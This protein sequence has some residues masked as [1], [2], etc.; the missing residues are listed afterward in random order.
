MKQVVNGET[1]YSVYGQSGA[2]LYRD[3][4]TTGETTDY[5]RMGGMTVARIKDDGVTET[6]SYLH[7][8]H[9]GS[10]VAATDT[11]GAVLWREDYTPFGEERQDPAANDNDE[12]FTGHIRDEATGLLY[13]QARYMD[14]ILGRFLSNDPVAFSSGAPQFF[15]RYSYAN[16]DPVNNFDP[17][18]K[19][20]AAAGGRLA[21]AGGFAIADGPFPFGDAIAVG[22]LIYTGAEL[23]LNSNVPQGPINPGATAGIP[24]LGGKSPVDAGQILGEGGFETSGTSPGGYTTYKH[25]DGSRITIKPDGTIVRTGPKTRAGSDTGKKYR[26]RVDSDGKPT[27]NHN[28]DEQLD[29]GGE[30]GDN[31]GGGQSSANPSVQT[32]SKF[33]GNSSHVVDGRATRLHEKD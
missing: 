12:N 29:T 6:V 5:V 32:G 23:V 19:Q 10:P 17:D 2:L 4:A 30:G 28:P 21:I 8:D 27:D 25:P 24:D 16:N 22:I 3:N 33:H 18:G 13:M 1:I 9:L 15:N 20:A 26:P 7:Q 11:G 31:G 14:P